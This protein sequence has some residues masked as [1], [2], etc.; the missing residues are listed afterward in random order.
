MELLSSI[1]L[2]AVLVVAA[3]GLMIWHVRAWQS[4]LALATDAYERDYRRRQFRRRMQTSAMLGLISAA[5]PVGVVVMHAWPKIGAFYWGGVLLLVGWIGLLALADMLATR[6]YYGRIR[7][8]YAI[9]E[10]KL[11]AE[12]N[13]EIREKG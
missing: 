1:L 4:S 10:A 9:E 3:A 8:D 11:H 2:A 12:L 7:R 6:H 5:L 13:R